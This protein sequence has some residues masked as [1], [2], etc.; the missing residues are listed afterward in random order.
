MNSR[1]EA[2][3]KNSEDSES[4]EGMKTN[5]QRERDRVQDQLNKKLDNNKKLKESLDVDKYF[6]RE[7]EAE[8][9]ELKSKL[10]AL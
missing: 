1:L 6:L 10:S 3:K 4:Q 9:D 2:Q 8:Y 7:R 5:L